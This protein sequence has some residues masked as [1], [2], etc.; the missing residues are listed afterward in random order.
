MVSRR[1]VFLFGALLILPAGVFAKGPVAVVASLTGS[2]TLS[3]SGQQAVKVRNLDWL[4]AGVRIEV[5][6][7]STMRLILLN[8]RNYELRGEAVVTID[9]S[10]LKVV[11]GPVRELNRLPPVPTIAPIAD[12]SSDVAGVT[13]MRTNM[14]KIT[15]YPHNASAIADQ[16][17]LWF[18]PVRE[19]SNYSVVVMDKDE[20]ILFRVS[21]EANT[22]E[23]PADLLKPGSRY[24]WRVRSFGDA[25]VLGEKGAVFVTLSQEDLARRSAFAAAVRA[26]DEG[27][28][29]ALIA[30]VDQEIGLL[31]EARDGYEAALRLRPS[32]PAIQSALDLLKAVMA[33]PGK[34]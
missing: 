11:A 4:G 25:G 21:T 7:N 26:E 31:A 33:A 18:D 29:L 32:D 2:A 12:T 19:A 14:P 15:L 16:V 23:V 3:Y 17:T 22:V 6:P 1:A 30:R 28:R 9:S 24:H 20:K 8:G 13:A 10:V 34:R 27:M 5:Q